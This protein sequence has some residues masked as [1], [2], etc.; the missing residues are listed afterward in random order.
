VAA[1]ERVE[2]LEQLATVA[3][4]AQAPVHDHRRATHRPVEQVSEALVAEANA[5]HGN[6]AGA[7]DIRADA[8]VVPA[9]TTI[10]SSP[11]TAASR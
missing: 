9:R 1:R 7:Q 3:D 10:G 11:K 6:L 5:E 2:V 8:E 4:R